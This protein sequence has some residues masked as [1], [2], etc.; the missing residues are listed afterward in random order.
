MVVLTETS[1]Y[2]FM[3]IPLVASIVIGLALAGVSILKD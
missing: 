1:F 3:G 2:F